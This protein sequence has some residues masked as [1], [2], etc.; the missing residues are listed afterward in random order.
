[1]S[2]CQVADMRGSSDS[3]KKACER[4]SSHPLSNILLSCS[5]I[6]APSLSCTTTRWHSLFMFYADTA[7]VRDTL[8][9]LV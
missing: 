1:M 8:A 2:S 9:A 4:A 5:L 6:A 7:H 3:S